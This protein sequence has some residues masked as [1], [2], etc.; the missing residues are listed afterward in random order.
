MV[1]NEISTYNFEMLLAAPDLE[2][3]HVLPTPE[4]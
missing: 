4:E 3:V 1:L 2:G